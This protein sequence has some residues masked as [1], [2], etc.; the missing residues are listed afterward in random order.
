MTRA[1]WK[2]DLVQH[3]MLTTVEMPE[4]ARILQFGFQRNKPQLWALVDP[5]AAVEAREFLLVS[6]GHN[7]AMTNEL[8]HIATASTDPDWSYVYHLFEVKT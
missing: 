2:F 5:E 7:I 8:I 4:G 3:S 1:V 6:T